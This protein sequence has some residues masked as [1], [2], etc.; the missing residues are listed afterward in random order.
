MPSCPTP[1][2]C[3]PRASSAS[4]TYLTTVSASAISLVLLSAF[5]V[6]P[7]DFEALLTFALLLTGFVLLPLGAILT[8]LA[9][10]NSTASLSRSTRAL[11]TAL[12][13]STR[14]ADLSSPTQCAVCLDDVTCAAPGRA[15]ACSHVFHESCIDAWVVGMLRNVCPLCSRV[16]CEGRNSDMGVDAATSCEGARR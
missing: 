9:P 5:T 2:L 16:V 4:S 11:R 6:F 1:N 14:A 12:A 7:A 15:L 13:S 3:P 10:S 8:L